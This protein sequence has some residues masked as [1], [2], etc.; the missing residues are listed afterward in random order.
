MIET[1]SHEN[2]A[3]I[4]LAAGSARRMQHEQHKL[5]L[6]L[7]ERPVLAHVLS[8]ALAATVS[9]IVVVLGH[10]ASIIKQEL[11]Q[12]ISSSLITYVENPES[13]TGMSSSLRAGINE[14]MQREQADP[15]KR[16]YQGALILLGDQPLV[17]TA[18][19][20]QLI[21]A[22]DATGKRIIVPRYKGKRGNPV[23]FDRSLWP[24]LLAITGDE[25]GKRV[26]G[27]YPLDVTGIEI[28]DENLNEDVDTWEAY[29]RVLE[30]WKNLKA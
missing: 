9:T 5:L 1:Q 8:A 18:L 14:L 27:S 6:P 11:S 23:F 19:I 25:G 28:A 20:H 30:I 7:G 2:I 24:E 3:A 4:V 13:R 22:R 17:S 26:I 16:A 29:Q 12:Y 15:D 10:D 21:R